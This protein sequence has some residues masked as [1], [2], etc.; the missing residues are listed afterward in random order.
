MSELRT[1]SART[2]TPGT[3]ASAGR[4][5]GHNPCETKAAR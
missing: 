4:P 1:T 2:G 3:T 5:T